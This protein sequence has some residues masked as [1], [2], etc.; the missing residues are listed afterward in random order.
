MLR[1][2]L[3]AASLL[4]AGVMAGCTDALSFASSDDVDGFTVEP[5][6]GD[7][8]TVFRVKA[9]GALAGLDLMWDFGDGVTATGAEAEHKYGF[10]NGMM[11][12]TLLATGADGVPQVATKSVKLGNG[13]NKEPTA[14]TISATKKWIAVGQ[15]V[16]LTARGNDLD[17]DPLTYLWTYKVLSGGVAGDGHDHDHG[18]TS[19]PQG[20]EIVIDG[21]TERT[22]VI[23]DAPGV[24]DV[25][26]QVSDPKGGVAIANTTISVSRHIPD[27]QVHIPFT[28]KL[29]VGTAGNG[30]S[31][32][33]WL[34]NVPDSSADA[35]RH[36]FELKYP[37]T[38]YVYLR[39]NDTTNQSVMDLDLELRDATTGETLFVGESHSVNP[40]APAP[41]I[42]L[43]A[44][45][46][47]YGEIPAG[48]YEIIVRGY[49]AANV[50]YAVDLFASLRL[51]PELVAQV[52]GS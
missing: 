23:F 48:S 30:A 26:V 6:E 24:Y 52:E 13:Q 8:D 20:G 21:A 34:D 46:I 15:S 33:L 4:V 32:Q 37:A 39:W 45:E 25:K 11:Q 9:A 47:A 43:P 36:A 19:A 38:G 41:P 35:A 31:E 14:G 7:K 3:L 12:I 18:G 17:R 40:E 22:S 28:G 10:T 44:I 27:A 16:N 2:L 50:E 42:P 1:P 29:L 49:L 5:T 51:T